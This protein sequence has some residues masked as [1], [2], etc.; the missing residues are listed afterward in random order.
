MPRFYCPQPLELNVLL[1]LPDAI[2]HHIQ[3]LRLKEGE[4]ITLFNGEGGEYA[5]SIEHIE[6]KQVEVR[7]KTFSAREAEPA[8]GLAL[9]QVLP[10]GSKMDWIIEKA[11]ELGATSVQPLL[12]ERSVIRL[13]AERATKKM[14]HWQGV[15]AAASEQC[16]RNR[17]PHLNEPLP[18]LNWIAQQ[19]LHP[20][21]LLSPRGTQNLSGWAK[22]H[23]AQAVTLIIGPEGGLT[24]AEEQA[25]IKHGALCLTMGERVLRTETAGL[26]AMAALQSI[27]DGL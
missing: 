17:L 4:V 15:M 27:W 16:G 20:R 23:P 8:H 5:A 3:V 18:F 22:H 26:A 25:A 6:K 19:D 14:S 21:L 13:N 9:A 1:S 10:E 24:P 2:A 12:S 7:L 11:V